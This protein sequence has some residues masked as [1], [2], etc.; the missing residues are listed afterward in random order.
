[1]KKFYINIYMQLT[2]NA[3]KLGYEQIDAP[4]S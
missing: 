2:F 3:Q 1:M 4:G